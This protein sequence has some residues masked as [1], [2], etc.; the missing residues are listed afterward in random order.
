MSPKANFIPKA[1]TP[2]IALPHH[3]SS[4]DNINISNTTKLNEYRDLIRKY[5]SLYYKDIYL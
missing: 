1:K 2:I 4:L 5:K 3:T